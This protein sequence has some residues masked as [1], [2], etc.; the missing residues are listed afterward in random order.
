MTI[1]QAVRDTLAAD[2]ELIMA[3]CAVQIAESLRV[4]L[5]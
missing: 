2:R 3:A 5:D 1:Q 4:S